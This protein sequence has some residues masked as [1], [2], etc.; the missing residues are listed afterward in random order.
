MKADAC[1]SSDQTLCCARTLH[2]EATY[3]ESCVSLLG[4]VLDQR[5]RIS[6]LIGRG[7]M[8]CVYR[9]EHVLLGRSVAIKTLHDSLNDDDDLI[10]RVLREA[11]VTAAIDSPHVVGIL[12]IGRLP[13]GGFYLVLEYLEGCGLGELIERHGTLDVQGSLDVAMQLCD[14][15][16]AVHRAGVIHRDIK[17]DNVFVTGTL[18]SRIK[19]LDFGVCKIARRLRNAATLDST[20]SGMML[21][22]PHYMAPEQ[23]DL[24]ELAGP[25]TD[26]Y[27]I[28]A[29]LHFMVTG[30]PPF[31][32]STLPRLLLQICEAELKPIEGQA[33]LT[34][35]LERALA[36]R[37]Q[38]RFQ[39]AGALRKALASFAKQLRLRNLKTARA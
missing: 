10:S 2:A 18:P 24:R 31:E 27:A 23:V 3:V 28:G 26:V 33:E 21:G 17:P 29:T 19:L 14:A 7:G 6:E 37:P 1:V 4:T 9:A 16:S 22:T 8:S 38:D 32:G 25:S 35:L 39:S 12:D 5:Y 34:R 11:R 15:V 36:K 20:S 13:T 30:R